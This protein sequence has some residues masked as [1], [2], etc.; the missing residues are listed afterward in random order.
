MVWWTSWNKQLLHGGSMAFL[1]GL[2]GQNKCLSRHVI[3]P[4]RRKPERVRGLRSRAL[5]FLW[6]SKPSVSPACKTWPNVEHQDVASQ[7]GACGIEDDVWW[8]WVLKISGFISQITSHPP[9]SICRGSKW[10]VVNG[11]WN[12]ADPI[13][14][15]KSSSASAAVSPWPVPSL[16]DWTRSGFKWF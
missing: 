2:K 6:S 11:T 5:H 1:F 14:W 3:S 7:P 16:C 8:L 9:S 13:G 10:G 12:S 15:P 4:W